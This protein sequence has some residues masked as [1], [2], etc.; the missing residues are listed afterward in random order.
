LTERECII[1]RAMKKYFCLINNMI[2][3]TSHG[4][5]RRGRWEQRPPYPTT[6]TYRIR[7][8]ADLINNILQTSPIEWA[9]K[10]YW[11]SRR[12]VLWNMIESELIIYSNAKI[13]RYQRRINR[14]LF[15]RRT[16]KEKRYYIENSSS[17][18]KWDLRF[19]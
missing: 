1:C 5:V 14:I 8:A 13:L 17:K 4:R 19:L 18:I 3:Q 6:L 9:A 7:F 11:W 12:K 15:G 16:Q 2:F 10:V